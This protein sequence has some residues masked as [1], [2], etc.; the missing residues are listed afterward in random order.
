MI[1]LMINMYKNPGHYRNNTNCPGSCKS[2]DCK[3]KDIH[4]CSK[5]YPG[6]LDY[7]PVKPATQNPFTPVAKLNPIRCNEFLFFSQMK[8]NN[9]LDVTDAW[10]STVSFSHLTTTDLQNNS[11]S[12]LK[13]SP[14]NGRIR[15]TLGLFS[16]TSSIQERYFPESQ[17]W[18]WTQ[19]K[20]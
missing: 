16:K 13:P 14:I 5:W 18:K 6:K 19:P 1:I 15:A 9:W 12:A 8:S 2:A 20:T 11:Q 17:E 3:E 4:N 10:S 7:L